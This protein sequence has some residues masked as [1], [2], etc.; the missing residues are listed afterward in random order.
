MLLCQPRSKWSPRRERRSN[1]PYS[2]LRPPT[3]TLGKWRWWAG[4]WQNRDV[5]R[6]KINLGLWGWWFKCWLEVCLFVVNV[7][8]VKFKLIYLP[9]LLQLLF[10]WEVALLFPFCL[11]SSRPARHFKPDIILLTFPTSPWYFVAARVN[12]YFFNFV[13]FPSVQ[14]LVIGWYGPLP[15]LFFNVILFLLIP[16]S[17]A[18]LPVLEQKLG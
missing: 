10:Q 3:W 15:L 12:N 5:Q 16:G 2:L 13:S 7:L 4:G 9:H 6:T 14:R 1:L 11:L 8:Q 17:D 18:N